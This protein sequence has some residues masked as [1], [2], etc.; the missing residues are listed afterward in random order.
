MSMTDE[1]AKLLIK[2]NNQM[3]KEILGLLRMLN[4]PQSNIRDFLMNYMANRLSEK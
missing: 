4:S 1:E 2:E 3:L